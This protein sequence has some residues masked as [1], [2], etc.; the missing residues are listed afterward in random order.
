VPECRS[1]KDHL[2]ALAGTWGGVS[3]MAVDELHGTCWL[4][5]SY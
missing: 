3:G 1:S 5:C 4:I 2:F